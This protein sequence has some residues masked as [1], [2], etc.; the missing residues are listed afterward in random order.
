M[1]KIRILTLGS[2]LVLSFATTVLAQQ[3]EESKTDSDQAA[4]AQTEEKA[5]PTEQQ[6][7]MESEQQATPAPQDTTADAE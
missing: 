6:N 3:T 2:I 1:K 7:A 5:A 4:A